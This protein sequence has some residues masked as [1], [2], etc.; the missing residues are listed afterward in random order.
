MNPLRCYPCAR[1]NS[2]KSVM[3]ADRAERCMFP[4]SFSVANLG[5]VAHSIGSSFSRESDETLSMSKEL[6]M[7]NLSSHSRQQDYSIPV[8]V[9]VLLLS[10]MHAEK[11]QGIA[12]LWSVRITEPSTKP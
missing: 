6:C 1:L 11:D 10:V 9:S 8:S 3:A 2:V 4:T 12:L 5:E 7:E